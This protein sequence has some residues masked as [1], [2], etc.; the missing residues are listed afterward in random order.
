MLKPSRYNI[1]RWLLVALVVAMLGGCASGGA[2]ESYNRN[3]YAVN[4]TV[5]EYTLKPVAKAYKAI[6]PDP[7]E[8]SVGNF[9]GNI[10]EVN[11]LANSLLQ[12]KFRNAAVASARIVWNTTLGLG[13][14]FDVASA[15]DLKTHP[16]DFGQ[17]L[18]TWGVPA[19][20]YIVLPILGPSTVTDTVGRVGD[21]SL[22]PYTYYH[23]NDHAV[24]EATTALRAINTRAKLLSLSNL[25]NQASTDE[26][27]FVKNGYLQR[28]QSLL[29]DGQ[30]DEKV[31]EAFDALFFDEAAEGL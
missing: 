26:Y 28:R 9:F 13:G 19:G 10:G 12:G 17:T 22:S 27:G 23:W 8:R 3:M 6:T 16:E 7:V 1:G 5:D 18:R 30:T 4:K 2:L 29:R 21:L 31:D 11:T 14:L 15:M 25:A 20:P 24:R